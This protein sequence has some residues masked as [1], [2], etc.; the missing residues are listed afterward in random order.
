MTKKTLSLLAGL[1]VGT[2][3]IFGTAS[4]CGFGVTEPTFE[5]DTTANGP[6]NGGAISHRGAQ[7][8]QASRLE[9]LAGL[10]FLS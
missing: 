1:A 3:L 9:G 2:T 6:D 4:G 7:G 8:E 5:D 10:A